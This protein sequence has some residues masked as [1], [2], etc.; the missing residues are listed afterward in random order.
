MK[1]IWTNIY[2]SNISKRYTYEEEKLYSLRF[3]YHIYDDGNVFS[4]KKKKTIR[5]F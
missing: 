5:N 1:P 2:C 3:Q 4:N